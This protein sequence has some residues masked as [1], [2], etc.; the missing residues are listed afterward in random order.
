MRFQRAAEGGGEEGGGRGL[1]GLLLLLDGLQ[2]VQGRLDLFLW[3]RGF[4]GGAGDGDVLPLRRH[5]VC[6]GDHADVDIWGRAAVT[7]HQAIPQP[8]GPSSTPKPLP[9]IPAHLFLFP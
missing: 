1:A 7:G 6:G 4:H 3:V 9:H 8:V 2:E 5:V